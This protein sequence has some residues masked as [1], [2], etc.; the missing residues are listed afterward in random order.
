[1]TEKT[2]ILPPENGANG[3]D[4]NSRLTLMVPKRRYLSYLRERWWVVMLCVALSLGGMI[5]SETLLPEKTSSYAVLYAS[6]EVQLSAVSLLNEESLTYFGTQTE[7]LKSARLQGAALAKIGYTPTPGEPPPV[8]IEV[9]QP[10]KTSILQL[11]ATSVDPTLPQRFLEALIE[12][13]VTYKKDTRRTT[14][15]EIMQNLTDHLAQKENE[16]RID[17]EKF[18]DFKR[19]N[20]VDVLEAQGRSAGL[21]LADLNMQLAKLKLDRE[22]LARGLSPATNNGPDAGVTSVSAQTNAAIDTATNLLSATNPASGLIFASQLPSDGQ[23]KT[24]RLQLALKQAEQERARSLH[25]DAA[26][27]KLDD[28]I[29]G[30]RNT[31]NILEQQNLAE[32][33]ANLEELDKRIAAI[34]GSIPTWEAK[35]QNMNERLSKADLLK[36][37][38]QRESGYYDHLLSTLE[39]ADLG[40]NV[41]RE[42]LSVL[43]APTS[44]QPVRRH[45]VLLSVLALVFGVFLSLALV[46]GWYLIDDRFVSV[47]DIKDQ[48][49]ETV[50]GLVPQIRVPKS[51]PQ[52]ALIEPGDTRAGYVESYRHLRSALL[53]SSLGGATRPQTLLFT[54]AAPAEGKTTISL[55]LARLLA[56][57]GLRVVV[58]YADANNC[59]LTRLLDAGS[60]LGVLDFLRGDA[61]AEAIVHPSGI[62]GLSFVPIGTHSEHAEGLFLRPKLAGMMNVLRENRDFVILD[63]A[64]ILGSDD[65]ALLVPHTDAVVL[66]TRPFYTQSRLVRQALDMLYQ[67]QAKSVSFIHNRAR[68]DDLSGHYA[69]NGLSKVAK[70]GKG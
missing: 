63:G 34:E 40:K 42:Q 44:P 53:L 22:L 33:N 28:E 20:N 26:A 19:T 67:R 25:G 61:D 45:P 23:L 70:N 11:Q 65:S 12:E 6:G 9:Y 7:I 1:M 30:W 16:L 8:K 2:I 50:L 51:K 5:A 60:Q 48:F 68:A 27:R 37:N 4:A 18:A 57:S 55:N 38:I 41:Q 64:P 17:Q 47:R 32:R 54:G 58:V 59:G 62:D 31:V 69:M 52:L 56:R 3:S 36:N 14:S 24:A 49:G 35:V 21:Y 13:Y 10:M 43:Q 66:V 29:A 15:D 39:N 46:F